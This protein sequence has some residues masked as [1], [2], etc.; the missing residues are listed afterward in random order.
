M[1]AGSPVVTDMLW[2]MSYSVIFGLLL[3]GVFIAGLLF[4]PLQLMCK[5]FS[6]NVPEY[7]W[8]DRF[9]TRSMLSINL[10]FIFPLTIV[11][12]WA[13][14][15]FYFSVAEPINELHDQA[16][17]LKQKYAAYYANAQLLMN[18]IPS[19]D[20]M[21]T[22]PIDQMDTLLVN[23]TT[24][25]VDA[26]DFGNTWVVR[27]AFGGMIPYLIPF[28]A[29]AFSLM[30]IIRGR[31]LMYTVALLVT[32]LSLIC[33]MGVAIPNSAWAVLVSSQCTAGIHN[34]MVRYLNYY[35]P[36]SCVPDIVRDYV[37]K[38]NI[39]R[40]ACLD[41]EG[42]T[43]WAA[44]KAK[45]DAVVAQSPTGN[46][47]YYLSNAVSSWSVISDTTRTNAL[48]HR[49]L[50]NGCYDTANRGA[51]LFLTTLL[52]SSYLLLHVY[53]MMF[54]TY[55]LKPTVNKAENFQK[56]DNEAPREDDG[57]A[58]RSNIRDRIRRDQHEVDNSNV[59][60]TTVG[61]G[62]MHALIFLLM[63][64]AFGVGSQKVTMNDS[65]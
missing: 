8:M 37:W 51:A 13:T 43:P 57:S 19:Y 46:A 62:V 60:W 33:M 45:I 29:V 1:D 50:D 7:S 11:G 28:V 5:V 31:R 35:N 55:R 25:L 36:D 14:A 54:S 23:R 44:T 48:Y 16:L 2:V 61:V 39:T 58:V 56:F 38:D 27:G 17:V 49:V 24:N 21:P 40:A 3:A 20:I 47:A 64:I 15:E 42:R 53:V 9:L 52:L 41:S 6:K 32:L 65:T 30:W 34:N 10:L 59:I 12:I 4:V 26:L 63:A 18:N 22:T